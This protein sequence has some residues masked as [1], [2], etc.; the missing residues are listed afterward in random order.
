MNRVVRFLLVLFVTA[1]LAACGGG[2]SGSSSS[3]T[4]NNPGNPSPGQPTSPTQP[5]KVSTVSWKSVGPVGL[6]ADAGLAGSGKLV[7]MAM[8]PVDSNLLLV[9]G[10]NGGSGLYRSTDGG[11]SWQAANTGMTTPDG[12]VDSEIQDVWFAPNQGNIAFAATPNGIYRS[13]DAGQSWSNV[14]SQTYSPAQGVGL[15]ARVGNQIFAATASGLLVSNDSGLTWGT[16]IAG[17]AST[18]AVANGTVLAAMQDANGSGLL[19]AYTNGQ[20]R[21]LPAT[22]DANIRQIAINPQ[23]ASIIYLTVDNGSYSQNLYASTNGGRS[24]VKVPFPDGTAYPNNNNLLGAQAIAFSSTFPQR[25]YVMGDYGAVYTAGDGSNSPTYVDLNV[26]L[27]VRR[28]YVNANPSGTNDTCWIASD[29]G[30]HMSNDCAAPNSTWLS[31]NGAMMTHLITGFAVSSDSANLVAMIQDYSGAYSNNGGAQWNDLGQA[32][33]GVAAFNPANPQRCYVLDSGLLVSSDGCK[34]L[35]KTGDFTGPTF[36][37]QSIAFDPL[38]AATMY[39][40][41]TTNTQTV[42]YISRDSGQTFTSLNWAD[43]NGNPMT[44]LSAI[45]VDPGNGNH[46][47]L[48]RQNAIVVSKDGKRFANASGLPSSFDTAFIAIQ[49]GNG[50]RVVVAQESGGAIRVFA[51]DDGGFN[52]V[53]MADMPPAASSLSGLAFNPSAG[54]GTPLLVLTSRHYGA[55]VSADT[56]TTWQRLDVNL[57]SHYFSSLQWLNGVLYLGT[58]GQGIVRSAT[59]LQ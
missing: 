2:D 56:G 52:F 40:L 20:W 26:G 8:S 38:N 22:L 59:A 27:D 24:F 44:D 34:T 51:S 19:Y 3:S 54:S 7:A 43:S 45:A 25:L 17:F 35:T 15:F 46:I 57:V 4:E 11:N 21:Q 31:L 32:E 13:A 10:D 9:G 6:S 50:N 1:V 58:Y 49:P 47:V 42:A 30:L 28:I 39:V 29:Q 18:I 36:Q 41:G 5:F 23:N 55:Y 12:L 16:A 14:F 33:D 48:A 37:G 53:K